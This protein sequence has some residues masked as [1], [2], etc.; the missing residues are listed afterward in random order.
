MNITIKISLILLTLAI[1]S[2]NKDDQYYLELS[3][4]NFE[5]ELS[6]AG[7]V[8]E[9]SIYVCLT[10]TK[11]RQFYSIFE[12][13][14]YVETITDTSARV[15]IYENGEFFCTLSTRVKQWREYINGNGTDT[16]VTKK[17]YVSYKELDENKNYSLRIEHSKY[18]IIEANA[19]LPA[20][21]NVTIDTVSIFHEVSME[22][23]NSNGD[24]H[25][26]LDTMVWSTVFTINIDNPVGISN[27]Y[28]LEIRNNSPSSSDNEKFR[29]N[30]G[31]FF[32]DAGSATIS[33]FNRRDGFLFSNEYFNGESYELEF[34]YFK[35]FS[36]DV[37]INLYSLSEDYYN[38]YKSIR[39]YHLANEDPF[40]KPVTIFSN[41]STKLGVFG[42][43]SKLTFTTSSD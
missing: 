28:K 9:D 38:Y 37:T 22:L 12:Y 14:D 6:L 30:K 31:Y 11:K 43:Y 21:P 20:L 39:E 32:N 40:S 24:I 33:Y 8:S 26:Y 36:D 10:E 41:V 13:P 18:G 4:D 25:N 16:L 2:C 5:P 23:E 27:Y 42:A 34:S 29:N 1:L 17:Y 7:F 35:N 19:L 15:D 3:F